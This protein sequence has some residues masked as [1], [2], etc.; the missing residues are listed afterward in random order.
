VRTI[1]GKIIVAVPEKWSI[2]EDDVTL[3]S[4]TQ[5]PLRL[6]WAITVHKS[7]GMTLDAVE[8]DLSKSF[9]YGMGYVAL[10]R[11]RRLDGIKLLGI[12]ETALEVNPEMCELDKELERLSDINSSEI[13]AMGFLEKRKKQKE[14]V[15]KNVDSKNL[16]KKA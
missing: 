14:F 13:D 3:A 6:A 15:E 12:N 10:S 4:V 1:S 11:V 5:V 16:T 7:Q 9:E 2:D 8:M